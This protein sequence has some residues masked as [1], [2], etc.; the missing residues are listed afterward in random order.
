MKNLSSFFIVLIISSI[1]VSIFATS[2]IT[3]DHLENALSFEL[4]P[5]RPTFKNVAICRVQV[6]V[7][8]NNFKGAESDAPVFVRLNSKDD[9]FYLNLSHNDRERNRTD[10]YDFLSPHVNKI[11]DIQF[12]QME[13][14]GR[15]G[16]N[17]KEINLI[18]NNIKIYSR[19]FTNGYWLDIDHKQRKKKL[20]IPRRT[21]EQYP[22]YRYNR[23]T[24]NIWRG[25]SS[26]PKGMIDDLVE[27]A[28]GNTLYKTKK[29]SWGKKQGRFF[30]ESKRINKN[31]LRYD[32]DLSYEINNAPNVEI[33]V[34]FDLVF[35]C[36]NGIIKTQV[37]N[38]K[39]KAYGTMKFLVEN[40]KRFDKY[41]Y[42]GCAQIPNPKGQLACYGGVWLVGKL[43]DFNFLPPQS[44]NQLG[45]PGN[46]G[47]SKDCSKALHLDSMGN[48]LLGK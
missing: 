47:L 7:K 19:K 26:I 45:S 29:I 27:S 34:D 11:K 33:D 35:T 36:N 23:F 14:K 6:Q 20:Y 48:L 22:N 38:Y 30:I 1:Q 37:K 25:P 2:P 39:S 4:P 46:I 5:F 32:L 41:L 24:K 42:K 15:D 40:M 28:V 43:L 16:W 9:P 44:Q 13:I 17:I 3:I 18:V 12:I 8:T 10:T 21:L 31:T